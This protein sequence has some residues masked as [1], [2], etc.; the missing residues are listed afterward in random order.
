MTFKRNNLL[1][2]GKNIKCCLPVLAVVSIEDVADDHAG[3]PHSSITNQHAAQLFPQPV[4]FIMS[5]TGLCH[6][7]S[8]HCSI[9]PAVWK[10]TREWGFTVNDVLSPRG[11]LVP[12]KKEAGGHLDLKEQRRPI[13]G[14]IH[15][16]FDWFPLMQ[17]YMVTPT[18]QDRPLVKASWF[19]LR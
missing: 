9:I 17:I 1:L 14:E 11:P 2:T 12:K 18:Q 13:R 7:S 8:Y 10:S 6:L 16:H 3:L 15:R 4:W 5:L 19:D